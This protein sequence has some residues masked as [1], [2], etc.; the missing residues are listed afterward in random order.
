[1]TRVMKLYVGAILLNISRIKRVSWRSAG[2]VIVV[3]NFTR[4]V[5]DDGGVISLRGRSKSRGTCEQV[6]Q[7]SSRDSCGPYAHLAFHLAAR[8]L[9]RSQLGAG[10]AI[11]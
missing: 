9:H 11:Q 4:F 3:A 6:G 2:T 1:M 8:G 7:I 5:A 10:R